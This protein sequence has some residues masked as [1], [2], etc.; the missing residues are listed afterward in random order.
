MRLTVLGCSGSCPG[1]ESPASSYL[2]EAGGFRMLLDVGNGSLGQLQRHIGV[3]DVDAVL[4]SHLHPDHCMDLLAL[5]V[6]RTYDGSGGYPQIPVYA[7]RGA[8]AHLATAYGKAER[9]GLSGCYDFREWTPGTHQV[10]PFTVTV[11]RVAHPV[12]A[13]G[14]RVE[15]AGAVLTYSGD[16]GPCEAL[17]EL[18]RDADLALFESS[19]QQGRDDDAPP[20]LHLTGGQ[21]GEA[22]A[23]AGANRLVLTHIPPWT[24]P[25]VCLAEAT[26]T[27]HGPVEVATTGA[28]FTL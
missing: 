4:L 8:A 21:A 17:V 22:A 24:E 5:Y 13:Y 10:G 11:A 2:V 19:F 23:K 3:G 28:V 15:H 9:P 18:A 14:I 26:R 16:T 12:E 1:P 7:P 27:F 25:Q 6:A 20:D